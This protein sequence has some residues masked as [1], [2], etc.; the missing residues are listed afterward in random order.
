MKNTNIQT[1]INALTNAG[2]ITE[3][4]TQTRNGI[5]RPALSVR[6]VGEAIG[7]I[8]AI[9][10]DDTPESILATVQKALGNRPDITINNLTNAK[11][12]LENAYIAVQAIGT[13]EKGVLTRTLDRFGDIA[14]C[15]K[16]A[17]VSEQSKSRLIY[18]RNRG[19]TSKRFGT[20]QQKTPL[21]MLLFG[22]LAE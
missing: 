15:V 12:L 10:E 2:Y 4:T 14:A 16:I 3:E 13:F 6:P 17:V 5:E 21:K 18:L 20:G 11:Y 9:H 7:I 8:I 1:L 22:T 19:L